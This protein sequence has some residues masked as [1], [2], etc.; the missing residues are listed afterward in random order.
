M[1][2]ICLAGYSG[3]GYVVAEI[4]NLLRY[5][6]R[7]YI[8]VEEKKYNPFKLQYLGRE[9]SIDTGFLKKE[10]IRIVLGIGD[11]RLRKKV[12]NFFLEKHILSETLL[13]P[14]SVISSLTYIAE[15]TIVMASAVINPFVKIGK[16]V[17]CNSGCII[18]HECF[19]EDF[20]HIAP[21]AVLVGN[22][23]V[24][25]NSF[26]GANSFIKQGLFIGNN[27]IIGAGS[28]VINN[29]PDDSIV[30]GNPAKLKRL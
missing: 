1:Q 4:A 21:G 8:D 29:I 11:N 12:F 6:L 30:Y 17:I 5:D 3:H 16:G 28:V 2:K 25:H 15:G 13:H 24:G 22:V 7:A 9:E 20:V 10:D 19:I 26:I 18:E 23:K 27:V 14:K